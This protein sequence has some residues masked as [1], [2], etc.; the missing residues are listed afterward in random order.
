MII[1]ISIIIIIIIITI[2]VVIV[3]VTTADAI[4]FVLQIIIPPN[5]GAC[6]KG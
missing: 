2:I 5:L 4:K 6:Q 3:V 1:S